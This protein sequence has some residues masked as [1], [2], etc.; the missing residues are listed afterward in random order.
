VAGAEV[1]PAE[2]RV[3]EH[4]ARAGGVFW[5]GRVVGRLFE[6][7][8]G[9]I[10][11]RAAVLDLDLA[12]VEEL[13]AAREKRYKPVRRYPASAFDLSIVAGRREL[14]GEL[15]K[16]LVTLAGETLEEIGFLYQY[17][18]APIPEGSKSVTFRLTV[19][20]ADHTMSD[21]EIGGI[22]ERIIQGMQRLGYELR[23]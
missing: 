18:G 11:G 1:R 2:P 5:R 10:A 14:V 19:A 15:Q 4:P 9:M 23:V 3:F 17:E 13:A 21:E 22:R 6:F 7:H 16:Y 20:A 8:P 12:A